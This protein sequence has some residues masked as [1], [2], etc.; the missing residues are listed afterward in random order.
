VSVSRSPRGPGDDARRLGERSRQGARRRVERR[1]LPL[2]GGSQRVG[3]S[4]LINSDG[5]ETVR[6]ADEAAG[7]SA[8]RADKLREAERAVLAASSGGESHLY[9]CRL[10]VGQ[11]AHSRNALV[12]WQAVAC[13]EAPRKRSRRWKASWSGTPRESSRAR[14]E[15]GLDVS[16]REAG[17]LSDQGRDGMPR[18]S[19]GGR[20]R[21]RTML[22]CS[23]GRHASHGVAR[24]E[25]GSSTGEKQAQAWDE[26]GS[27]RDA[28]LVFENSMWWAADVDTTCL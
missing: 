25:T 3:S 27:Q 26:T 20:V 17:R 22:S 19:V 24:R 2:E 23:S 9:S 13:A 8:G 16:G 14:E 10:G 12:I 21:E 1:A 6:E 28:V 11:G 18:G 15:N 7:V 5:R 4:E